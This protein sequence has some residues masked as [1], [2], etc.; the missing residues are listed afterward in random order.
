MI[1]VDNIYVSDFYPN[2]ALYMLLMNSD[3]L[4]SNMVSTSPEVEKD[5]D[6]Y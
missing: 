4:F 1:N 3:L 6:K 2:V 5:V